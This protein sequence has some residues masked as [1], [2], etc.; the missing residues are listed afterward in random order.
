MQQRAL[1]VPA[2]L[3]LC[4]APSCYI[5]GTRDW[6]LQYEGAVLLALTGVGFCLSMFLLNKIAVFHLKK[7]ISGKDMAKPSR[8]V[9]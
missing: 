2:L 1:L 6:S 8:P 7:G 5:L 4:L 3:A 9:M